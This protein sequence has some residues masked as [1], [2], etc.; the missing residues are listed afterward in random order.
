MSPGKTSHTARLAQLL[1]RLGSPTKNEVDVT[2]R[3]LKQTLNNANQNFSDLGNLFESGAGL[4]E[5]AATKIYQEGVA[6]GRRQ[7][8]ADR[9]RR[10]SF[11]N[12][13]TSKNVW[14]DVIDHIDLNRSDIRSIK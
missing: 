6:D 1:R 11:S 13:R 2:L 9:L 5:A 12:A 3:A 7:A 8:E 4:D 10:S 14:D